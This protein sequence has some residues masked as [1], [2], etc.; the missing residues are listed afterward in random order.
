[1]ELEVA[2]REKPVSEYSPPGDF[3]S[4]LRQTLISRSMELDLPEMGAS[5]PAEVL[6][7]RPCPEIEAGGDGRQ[8]ITGTFRH[9]AGN[10]LDVYL[11]G[12]LEPIGTTDNH[13]FWSEDRQNFVRADAL[14]PG[15]RLRTATGSAC[16][17][18]RLVPHPT[19]EVV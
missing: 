3:D 5:G 7:I 15:E 16:T 2:A 14:R 10:V 8:V 18:S 19:P 13:P 9:S 1:M 4:A 17:V 12:Q 11:A 6:W